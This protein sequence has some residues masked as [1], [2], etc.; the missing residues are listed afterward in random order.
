M[1]LGGNPIGSPWGTHE[2][3]G[4]TRMKFKEEQ[5]LGKANAREFEGKRVREY[6]RERK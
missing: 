4:R 1:V 3:A 6:V 2:V 5:G